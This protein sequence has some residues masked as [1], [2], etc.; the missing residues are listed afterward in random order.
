MNHMESIAILQL[1]EILPLIGEGNVYTLEDGMF[2]IGVRIGSQRMQNFVEHGTDCV[3]CGCRGAFFSLERHTRLNKTTKQR[4]GC[5]RWHMNLYGRN[6]GGQIRLMTRDHIWPLSL[7]GYDIMQN[8]CTMCEDCNN[9]KGNTPPSRK[10]VEKHGGA[11]DPNFFL[12]KGRVD[13]PIQPKKFRTP[14]EI[15]EKEAR[16]AAWEAN[17]IFNGRTKREAVPA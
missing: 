11:Y 10:F 17:P 16:R 14:E 3:V 12:A 6:K 1:H 15:A 2:K 5:G 8:Y 7:G 13:P 4:N 9:K